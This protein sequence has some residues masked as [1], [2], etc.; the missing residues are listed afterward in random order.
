MV[1]KR[2]ITIVFALL[3]M[4]SMVLA[5][6]GGGATPAA[7]EAA[8]G[9]MQSVGEGEGEV[10][11]VAW[12]GYIERGETDPGYDWVTEFEKETG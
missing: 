2:S 1:T 9:P 8:G 4:A 12:A 6:C 5:G 11:I 7:T 10:S 3:V